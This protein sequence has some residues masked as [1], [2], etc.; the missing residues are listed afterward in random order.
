MKKKTLIYVYA[1]KEIKT[2]YG[3][4]Y[5]NIGCSSDDLNEQAKLFQ[6]WSNSYLNSQIKIDK[7][8]KIEFGN[9]LAYGSVFGYAIL[10]LIK[11]KF[12]ILKTTIFQLS[13]K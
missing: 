1:L 12:L 10:S 9:I 4:N 13:T 8:I 2:Q 3:L 5:T 6:F 7:F 11:R